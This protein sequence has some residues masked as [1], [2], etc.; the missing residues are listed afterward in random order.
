MIAKMDRH[1]NTTESATLFFSHVGLR[2]K[3][4]YNYLVICMGLLLLFRLYLHKTRVE[5]VLV[6]EMGYK[7]GVFFANWGVYEKKHFPINM[8]TEYLTHVFYAFLLIDE[9]SGNLKFSDEWCDVN[10]PLVSANDPAK[11]VKGNL[12]QLFQLK[13]K[14]RNLK[15]IMSVGGWGTCHLFQAVMADRAKFNNFVKS[16]I[17]FVQ[18]YG[19]DG[20][21]IDWEFPLA[22][23][24]PLVVKLLRELRSGLDKVSTRLSLSYCGSALDDTIDGINLVE[25]DQYLSF[26]NLMC[27]DFS[28]V[29]YSEKTGHHSNL[30]GSNGNNNISA[31]YLVDKYIKIGIPAHKLLL[32]M[33][34]YGKLFPGVKKGD[35][36][37]SFT[38][39]TEETFHYNKI[40]NGTKRYDSAKVAAT[41]YDSSTQKFITY[42]DE[43][44]VKMKANFTKKK[45]LGGGM[46]WESSGDIYDNDEQSLI[47]NYIDQLG[48]P[49]VLEQSPNHL[50]I[51]DKSEYLHKLL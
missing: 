33:P 17:Y 4:L 7:S 27:Y 14:N 1:L 43:K 20:V 13:Q 9:E 2:S 30:F 8:R 11:Q 38:K 29:S 16:C 28:G 37:Q 49:G 5:K 42:D 31:S 32:G 15:V 36:G 12:Q 39:G 48:G 21:D 50:D 35:I 25:L 26:W 41:S 10:M 3:H 34:L 51:Y 45:G 19:F 18:E 22:H 47:V 24:H 40:P 44:S 6:E 46:W 23:E